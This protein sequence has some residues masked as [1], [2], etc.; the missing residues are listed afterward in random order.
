MTQGELS[1]SDE[2]TIDGSSV[3]G[4]VITAD[5]NDDD[6]TLPGTHITDVRAS[7]GGTEGAS[8]DL[9][10]DNSRVLNSS[11]LSF[12]QTLTLTGLTITGGRT[13]D[14]GGGIYVHRGSVSLADS[15]VSGNYSNRGG[16][17]LFSRYT[18][19]LSLT[20]SSVSGNRRGGTGTAG[21]GIYV[22]GNV[23]LTNNSSV[24][25]NE[26]GAIYS[27]SNVS[28]TD[29]TVS[30]NS[31]GGIR[32]S[33]YSDISL[34]NST[35]SGNSGAR[36]ISTGNGDVSLINSVVSGNVGGG[37]ST[38][39]GN[40]SLASSTVSDNSST[41]DGGGIS[42]DG[43]VSLT[44]ST[45][46]GNSSD[47]DGGG[48][49]AG[50]GILSLTNS[51][52]SG[53]S[54][55]R[56]GGGINGGSY[57][58][59]SLT[60]STVSGNSSSEDGGGIDAALI[61]LTNSTVSDN[62][63]GGDGGGIH[64][65]SA[66]LTNSTVSSNSSGGDGG[67]VFTRRGGGSGELLITNSTVTDNSASG[68]GGGIAFNID[69]R[70][71]RS[72]TLNNS[73]V[74]GN[75]D[76]GTA[77]DVVAVGDVM[78]DLTVQYSLIGDTTGSGITVSTGTG[79]ILNQ[80]PLLGPL[81]DNG[82]LT[83]T[84]ALLQ[85]S[86]AIDTG[87]NALAVDANGTLTTDQ[88]GGA[89]TRFFDD[90]A[91]PGTGVDIG[92][93]E[94]RSVLVDN[95]ID[96]DDGIV[97]VGDLSLREA[98]RLASDDSTLDVIAFDANVFTGGD[99]SVIRLTLGELMISESVRIDGTLATD[100]VITADANNDDV[101]LAG[102]SI[103][104]VLASFGGTDGA[105]DDLLD[106]NSRVLNFSNS[107]GN[108]TLAGL[109]ITGGQ[110]SGRSVYG[111]GVLFD[112]S[113]ALTVD[114]AIVSG[115]GT[116]GYLGNGGGIFT[117]AG[118]V[119]LNNSTVS[120]NNTKGDR[121]RGGG[122]YARF[123][124]VSLNNSA[125]SN[126]ST[127]GSVGGGG[128]GI[129]N[130]V[131]SVSLVS[132]TVSGNSSSGRAGDGGGI[133]SASGSVSLINSSV[134]GNSTTGERGYGGG[135]YTRNG[136][137]T[138]NSSTVS[139]NSTAGYEGFGGGIYSYDG[140]ISLTNSTLSGNSTTGMGSNGGGIYSIQS[141]VEIVNSTVAENSSSG[142]GGGIGLFVSDF[143]TKERLTIHN[144]IVAGNTD[145]GTAPDVL[146]PD[147]VLNDLIVEHSLIGDT[148]GSG[149]TATT[150]SGNI[151]NQSALLGPLADNGGPTL[152]HALLP[153]SP[154]IDVGNNMLAV[155]KN[156]NSLDTDQR[157]EIRVVGA[158]DIGAFETQFD[159]VRNLV[160]TTAQDIVDPSDGLTS[161]R[162]A[163]AFTNLIFSS[164]GESDTITFDASV[165]AGGDSNLIRLTEGELMISDSLI[166]DGSSVGDVVITGDANGDDVIV[167][168]TDITD[169]SASFGE[170]A[171][172]V[173]DLL[174]DN[175][176]VINFS[177][178]AGDLTLAGLT[179]TGGRTTGNNVGS[180]TTHSGGGI[181][182]DSSGSLTLSVNVSGNSTRGGGSAN[183]GGIFS[184]DGDVTLTDSTVSGNST[185]LMFSV[186]S[187]GGI[188]SSSGDISLTNS[189]VIGN[190]A[191]GFG[192][193]ISATFGNVSLTNN[194]EVS[195]N[196]SSYDG[197]G[198]L[199]RL[200]DVSLN[201]SSVSG[202]VAGYNNSGFRSSS[203]GGILT[204]DGDVFLINSTVSGNSS[205]DSGGGVLTFD[206][207]VS[208]INSTL[209]GNSSGGH[210]GGIWARESNVVI[211]SS[212]IANNSADIGGGIRIPTSSSSPSLTLHNSIVAGNSDNGTAPD[213]VAAG[214]AM[215]D[216]IV[217]NSLIGDTTGS[218]IT[219]TTGLGNIL[220]QPALLA[221][222]SDNGGPTLTHALLSGS[223]AIDAGN[224]VL[225][226]DADGNLLSTDQRGG[227]S[228]RSFDDPTAV[229][230]GVDIGAFELHALVVDNQVDEDDGNHGVGDLSLREA[231]G[232][233]NGD[234]ELDTI[235]FAA[236]VFTGGDSNVIR[237][238]QGQLVV[239]DALGIDATS[240]GGVVLTGD[241]ND[242]DVTLPGTH[243]TDVSASFGG[244]TGAADDLLDDN[245]RVLDFT[246]SGTLALS[247]LTVTGGRTE[248]SF[249]GGGIR[250]DAG[251]LSLVSSM[252]SGNKGT[253]FGGGIFTLS[254][255]V[256]LN[257]STVSDNSTYRDGGGIATASG[258]VSLISSTISGN[259][260]IGI[261]SGEGGGIRTSSGNVTLISSTL[262]GNSTEGE[263]GA[264]GGIF[265]REGNVSLTS[266]TLSG[267]STTGYFGDGG[268]I[269]TLSG[270]I[271][272]TSSTIS[273]NSTTGLLAFGGGITTLGGDISLA[274][275]TVT[276][277]SNPD[278]GTGGGI[279]IPNSSALTLHNSIVAGNTNFD[280]GS[281]MDNLIVENSLIGNTNGSGI[282][283][284]TGTGN[285]LNQPALLGP[286]A[287]NGGPTLT[288][289]LLLGSPA[290]N[291]GSNALAEEL[292]ADQRGENRIADQTVDIGA[293][294][295]QSP[296]VISTV[297]DEGGVLVRPDLLSTFAV[298]FD[299]DVNVSAEDLIVRSDTLFE[300]VDTSSVTLS[301]D[302]ATLTAT[303]DFSN[304]MLDASFYTFELSDTITG[305]VS[306]LPLDGDDNGTTDRNYREDVYVAIPGDANL[307][308]DVEVND[309]N[310][311]L[312]TNT[313]DGATVLSNLDR[314]GTFVWSQ[315]DFN[316]DGDVDA[317]QLNIFTGQQ[318]G[319]YAI[320]LAN[321][322][323][324]VRPGKFRPVTFQPAVSQPL[325]A[326]SATADL[327][328]VEYDALPVSLAEQ[329]KSSDADLID[330]STSVKQTLFA[331]EALRSF[332]PASESVLS[333][334][335]ANVDVLNE[336][337]NLLSSSTAVNEAN[338]TSVATANS[339]LKLGGA[340]DLLDD[341]FS[342]D[343]SDDQGDTAIDSDEAAVVDF[344]D[345]WGWPS[346][347]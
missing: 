321:L 232:L 249:S 159:G 188:F 246:G 309:I 126:N 108:L 122:V 50:R 62:S 278:N 163:I 213:V 137:V 296:I 225:A 216:L 330:S 82:G 238:T 94:L 212:T 204:S 192:G 86:P 21:G 319:D 262:S 283:A 336:S 312:G 101:T 44:D 120:E 256:S 206:G 134:S 277:N 324:D 105:A 98:I 150:G 111:G 298:T 100:V 257:S 306:G 248:D 202:N 36:G 180:E 267:N 313:G 326:Q 340:H 226:V 193:G 25:G 299:Q 178:E 181:R 151:L 75:T 136:D 242:D 16:G 327:V 201:N 58:T 170:L 335:Q 103:T 331:S 265:T 247:R 160:V 239:S 148:T 261:R 102:T 228:T 3:G 56:S 4:V 124:I 291:A 218:E 156:G 171:G 64:A 40:I 133:G 235:T 66:S 300:M 234:A 211:V 196:S 268:G 338:D 263:R 30:G 240:V 68:T 43:D 224:D 85:G 23:F 292:L 203:G 307:D 164:A 97:A 332:V 303:W 191:V 337:F 274:N 289:A 12:T 165:F 152:T 169:V 219:T 117:D 147:D 123:G 15:T 24:S 154:A 175:S 214:V 275:S 95:P 287:D 254:G 162:E 26:G 2:L 342:E 290:I 304:L 208:V 47:G 195:G 179:L 250:T 295:L 116:S 237:L 35:V 301:Y 255:N 317:T 78:N 173:D 106:D 131:G 266:S 6:I 10:D 315:G 279:L 302:P 61:S 141:S 270:D 209:S 271:S 79:N 142:V 286:L 305:V 9:L 8:D 182:F 27:R 109:T 197:G 341:I 227:V 269:F 92:S 176:R 168:G 125:V 144:S 223:P 49:S 145:N 51:T 318:N 53:N 146:A 46:S 33:R 236:N 157:G 104:D 177:S 83:Q 114:Q 55:G 153:D 183:G 135:I 328:S 132:S 127:T 243:I 118:N 272:L 167:D 276:G 113:G 96:E 231:I 233:V 70:F 344:A 245:S 215:N 63:G 293:L 22:G 128:A 91:A 221:P 57:Y 189:T 314:P 74:A 32:T 253:G 73:I 320:F 187:G 222:L 282:T 18:G 42:G 185:T 310:I 5:A 59:V 65:T 155:D 52:V 158:V 69:D 334:A 259:S 14:S 252:V 241:A 7:F 258:D 76:D 39:R 138:L 60:N 273:G 339:R 333:G 115:N 343:I 107:T 229:G 119:F 41:T 121:G 323:R 67:G 316:G 13:S 166:I 93:F 311:F 184:S 11:P 288:H 200:G 84:H 220:N 294:E 37:I 322:G 199:T 29:S 80:L 38:S 190:S 89:F 143:T 205:L 19:S 251:S 217:E 172:D 329:V 244:T 186:S 48:I 346:F 54:S 285:I 20:N 194:S 297:R 140:I 112:S 139:G 284:A 88:R 198:I 31:G 90:P 230:T 81:A 87:D 264:G 325:L 17:G 280:I 1:I 149:I 345:A 130:A 260:N 77:P 45:V 308:G 347:T 110:V 34:V 281:G 99:S 161:L 71:V 207:D 28:L 210:G 72:L 174:D 129:F